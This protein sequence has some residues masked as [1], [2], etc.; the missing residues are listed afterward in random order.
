M[1]MRY[2]LLAAA[3]LAMLAASGALADTPS[4][5]PAQSPVQAQPLPY[6]YMNPFDPNWWLATL[7]NMMRLYSV[8][9]TPP[10]GSPAAPAP[11]VPFF[12]F[13]V[14]AVAAP[15]TPAQDSGAYVATETPYG[16]IYTFNYADPSAWSNIFAQPYG[17]PGT[18]R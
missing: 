15:A 13:Y 8:P 6:G 12:P 17:A 4:Q 1:H 9:M 11:V 3:A 7:N 2:T 18:G 14:P 10:A 16:T 5:A